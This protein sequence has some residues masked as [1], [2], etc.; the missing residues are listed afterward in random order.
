MRTISESQDEAHD[1]QTDVKV[2]Q[3]KIR[4][5]DALETERRVLQGVGQ[6]PEGDVEVSLWNETHQ[7]LVIYDDKELKGIQLTRANQ[8]KIRL[9]TW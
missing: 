8:E 2:F 6:N 1:Q 5:V 3:D 7:I 4:N 9:K